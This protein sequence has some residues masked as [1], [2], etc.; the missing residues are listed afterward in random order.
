MTIED[1]L[2]IA[3]LLAEYGGLLTEKQRDTVALYCDMDLSLAE[4]AGEVGTSRQAVR[5]VIVRSVTT[6][7]DYENRLGNVRLKSAL[8]EILGG[9][10]DADWQERCRKA[11]ALLEE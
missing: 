8:L 11:I 3:E 2:Q 4:V 6:L 5:D 7:E 9:C 10:T 1:R